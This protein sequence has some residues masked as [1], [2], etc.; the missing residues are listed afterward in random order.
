[1]AAGDPILDLSDLVNLAT[2]GA[3]GSPEQVNWHKRAGVGGTVTTN[4]TTFFTPVIGRITSLWQYDG[5]PGSSGLTAPTTS[6]VC[7]NATSGALGQATSAT[8]AKKRL[9][10]FIAS[11]LTI[12]EVI[13]YDRLCHHGGLSGT[14]TTA[15]TTNLPTAALTRRT[16]GAGVEAWLEVYNA[17]GSTGTTVSASYTDDAGTSGNATPL[18]TFGGTGFREAQRVLPL[19]LAAG[20]RGARAVASVTVT[21]TTATAGNFGVTLAY[22][23]LSMPIYAAASGAVWSGMMTSGGP[24]DLGATSD[25]CLALAWLAGAATVPELFGHA[26]F[27]EK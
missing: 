24:L 15:Q 23:L 17:V 22:P 6:V 11:C 8:G 10:A 1:M 27:V 14:V 12:G 3:S 7:N 25:S 19:P 18:T 5:Q 13:L 4:T 20:D 26:Y 16:T 21:A 9:L 2:G